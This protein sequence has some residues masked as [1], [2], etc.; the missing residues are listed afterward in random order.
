MTLLNTLMQIS[1]DKYKEQTLTV[2]Q[3]LNTVKAKFVQSTIVTLV[4]L[5]VPPENCFGKRKNCAKIYRKIA[6]KLTKILIR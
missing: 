4:L 1:A 3:M 5:L 2:L 6:L